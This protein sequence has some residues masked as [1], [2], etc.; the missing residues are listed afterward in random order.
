MPSPPP[1]RLQLP[2]KG[3]PHWLPD[4]PESFDLGYLAWGY[5]W[6]GTSPIEPSRHGG[7]HYFMVLEGSP[8]LLVGTRRIRTA[9][10]RAYLADPECPIGHIDQGN[11]RSRIVVWIW[12]SPP[13]H[14]RIRPPPGGYLA[15]ALNRRSMSRLEPLREECH[16]AVAAADEVGQLTLRSARIQLDL[17]LA[18]AL[19]AHQEPNGHFRFN[20]ATTFLR[21]NLNK[22]TPVGD[23]C[24]YLHVS[25]AS[26]KRLFQEQAGENPRS[27]HL[28]LK[29]A[30]ARERLPLPGASVKAVAYALGYRHSNDFSRAFRRRCG[31]GARSL[32]TSGS[33]KL[34]SN[35][36][37]G[38]G[39]AGS[40]R[41]PCEPAG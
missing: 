33:T 38:A 27:F 22:A 23:L 35:P 26:L 3:R 28:G 30:W 4:E 16:R 29:M 34:G 10:G 12:R 24:D 18:G 13:V 21:N 15:I 41:S 36:P 37:R 8:T 25:A 6:F 14:S 31:I 32:L 7:W 11:R 5:R 39:R 9:P 2:P 17:L 19:G 40:P 20:L 1:R